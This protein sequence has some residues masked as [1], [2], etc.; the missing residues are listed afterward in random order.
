VGEMRQASAA[1]LREVEAAHQAMAN[2]LEAR[3][4][5]DHSTLAENVAAMRGQLQA[6]RDALRADL[7]QA[8]SVWASFTSVMQHRR[9]KKPAP[10]AAR[11]VVERAA[12]ALEEAVEAP[13]PEEEVAASEAEKAVAAP[14]AKEEGVEDNLTVIRGIGPAMQRHLNEAGIFTFAQLAKSTAEKVEQSLGDV[15]RLVSPEEWIEEAKELAAE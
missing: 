3:L 6:E 5:A 1:F 8:R 7:D 4:D 9:R 13:E 14:E 2:D 10:P 11:K 15:A 12:A